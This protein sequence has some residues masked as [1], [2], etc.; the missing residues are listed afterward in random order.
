MNCLAMTSPVGADHDAV[1]AAD[2]RGRRDDDQI[3]VA[4]H[5]LHGI[6]ADLQRIGVGIGDL[7]QAH[8]VPAAADREAA[9]VEK[10][11]A[12]GL[13]KPISGIRRAG[14]ATLAAS[15]RAPDTRE[16]KASRLAP[17]AFSTLATL[18]VLGQRFARRACTASTG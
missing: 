12:A 6:A 5:R 16:V 8:L 4:K 1:A 2:R 9:I 18:S 17:V 3:A 7:G 11:L 14:R 13:C 10:A 15:V